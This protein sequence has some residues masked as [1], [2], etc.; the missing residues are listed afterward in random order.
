MKIL[1][2]SILELVRR[3]KKNGLLL[4]AIIIAVSLLI[5]LSIVSNA[6]NT[7][8]LEVISKTGHTLTVRPAIDA[9]QHSS[10]IS[11]KLTTS[12][13]VLGKY[14]PEAL[15]P[16]IKKL[17]DEA[18]KAGWEKKG[19][20]VIRP[21]IGAI[22]LEPPTWA[23]RLYQIS[24]VDGREVI[25][26]GVE[27]YREYF[28]RFWWKIASGQWPEDS[29]NLRTAKMNEAVLGSVF[30][31]SNGLDTGA[32]VTVNDREFVVL[33]VLEET[34]SADDY[35]IFGSSRRSVGGIGPICHRN[36]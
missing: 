7:A 33:G 9:G 27:F 34:N 22:D 32:T 3:P 18:I 28:V 12:E 1:R 31:S 29:N 4:L 30:A 14:I 21:G 25:V 15:L 10:G 36:S 11:G 8:V 26:T 17:Y 6:A 23:P 35:M 16:E 13:V 5:S 2:L 24:M 19:G 20:L